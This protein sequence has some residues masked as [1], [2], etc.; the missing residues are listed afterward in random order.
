MDLERGERG[1]CGL[2][3]SM[4][5][6]SVQKTSQYSRS[7]LQPLK[8]TTTT[9]TTTKQTQGALEALFLS[10]FPP[11]SSSSC[12]HE[13]GCLAQVRFLRWNSV[14]VE[15]RPLVITS[16]FYRTVM[17][18]GVFCLKVSLH[19]LH[20]LFIPRRRSS[21]L[22]SYIHHCVPCGLLLHFFYP[23]FI[24]KYKR[25]SYLARPRTQKQFNSIGSLFLPEALARSIFTASAIRNAV[26]DTEFR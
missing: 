13:S 2:Y 16:A 5:S 23:S 10:F 25:V 9:T 4:E 24:F 21:A 6:D 14:L 7:L 17:V 11:S 19:R 12:H 8:K 15:I 1:I 22:W 20:V 3:F 26:G 18:C